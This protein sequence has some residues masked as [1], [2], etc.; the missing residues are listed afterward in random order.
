MNTKALSTYLGHA[1]V[2]ITLDR[3]G[4]LMPG[5][6]EEAAGLLD[7]YLGRRRR[8]LL[9]DP[10]RARIAGRAIGGSPCR[11]VLPVP[12]R[13]HYRGLHACAAYPRRIPQEGLT[14]EFRT[15]ITARRILDSIVSGVHKI[16][17]TIRSQQ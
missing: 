9:N 2:V 16:L 7:S 13:A 4:Q 8:R 3:Y 1:S 17:R 5:N 10:R 6:E 12:S 14:R 15:R 11:R